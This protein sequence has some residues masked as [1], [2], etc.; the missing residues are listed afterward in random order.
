MTTWLL[1]AAHIKAVPGRKTEALRGWATAT[2]SGRVGI[3]GALARTCPG[4]QFADVGL[5]P[6]ARVGLHLE[7]V[8]EMRIVQ[9]ERGPFRP[10]P[11]ELD[12]VVPGRWRGGRPF[13]RVAVSPR[14][15]TQRE[16]A[17][18]PRAPDVVDERERGGAEDE[19]ADGR[20]GVHGR[21]LGRRQLIELA[22]RHAL[23]AETVLDEERRVEPDEGQD[24]K[25]VV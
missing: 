8:Q 13:Q 7:S 24:R 25:S 11:G 5:V 17:V 6:P 20:D 12:E 10:D 15:V 16:G 9:L 21:E 19:R 18:L 1:N 23:V 4:D 22:P 14:V 3:V 2:S